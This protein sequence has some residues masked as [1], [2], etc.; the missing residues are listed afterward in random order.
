MKSYPLTIDLLKKKGYRKIS[1]NLIKSYIIDR[2][3]VWN[4]DDI[5]IIIEVWKNLDCFI[6]KQVDT[7]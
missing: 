4:K 2:Y 3:E 7:I 6:Y 5:G 1:E